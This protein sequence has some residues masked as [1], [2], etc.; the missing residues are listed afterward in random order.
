MQ[1]DISKLSDQEIE[2]EIKELEHTYAEFLGN[3]AHP[4][5]L[6]KI[7]KEILELQKELSKRKN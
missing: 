5:D 2:E 1:I 7:Y 6:H 4:K 3:D